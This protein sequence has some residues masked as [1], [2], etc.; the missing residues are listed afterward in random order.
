MPIQ[1]FNPH[2]P[3][4]D[5][6][7]AALK[8]IVPEA[9]EDGRLNI[10]TLREVLQPNLDPE[11][12]VD[13]DGERFGLIWPG[14]KEARRLA[15]IPS[16]GTL[17]PVYGEGLK[18]DGTPDTDGQNDS[19]NVFIEGENLEVLKIMQKAYAGRVKMIY[20]DPPYNT[21]NDFVYDDNFTEPL[22]HY[23]RRTGQVDDEGQNLTTNTK[24]DG[25][26]HS[27]WL[28]MMYPRLRLAKD[29][30]VEEGLLFVSIDDSEVTNLKLLLDE[31]F[32]AE[33]FYSQITVQSNKRGQTYKEIAKTHEYLLIYSKSDQ[34]E[35]L[36][37]EK[38]G[39]ALPYT[40]QKGSYD[41]WELRNRNPKFGRHNRPNLFYPFY[42]DPR[43]QAIDGAYTISL[44]RN[45]RYCQEILPRNSKGEDSCWRWGKDKAQN[46]L[47]KDVPDLVAKS[48][49]TGGY[50]IYQKSRKNTK[51]AKSI[52]LENNVISEKGTVELGELG[53]G[54]EFDHP[55]PMGLLEKILAI[56][57]EENDL[58]LDFFG[59]SGT[60][61][62]AIYFHNINKLHNIHYIIVQ[63]GLPS[64]SQSS[65]YSTLAEVT[66][67]RIK[68]TV[69]SD[70]ILQSADL[71][72]KAFMLSESQLIT[73][74]NNET[75]VLFEDISR[76]P[77][78]NLSSLL[79][80]IILSEGFPLNSSITLKTIED[81]K[82][83]SV[84]SNFHNFSLHCCFDETIAPAAAQEITL[85]ENDVL[86]CFDSALDDQTKLRLSDKGLVKTI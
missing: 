28:S 78:Y 54:K 18:A 37:L 17:A 12:T 7:L 13:D 40:D 11:G 71:G 79:W 61:A 20:I 60:T 85:G 72:F 57:V 70:Q 36:E 2:Y 83:H 10:D 19:R 8:Q 49:R 9:F 84:S 29:L 25:R 3:F 59:G 34:S 16:K 23:L 15:A 86:I 51:K 47:F 56:S 14:K 1:P 21:G 22:E 42:V 68:R 24:A 26:F 67:E 6:K 53:L 43:E 74:K 46:E 55:K 75:N 82:I 81:Q 45:E 35:I 63:I 62:S 32:G 44:K 41:L 27:R 66:R 77:Q 5:E 58:V 39:D 33:N 4:T 69:K 30:L 73:S 38:D 50:N 52:W 48:V 31:V 64:N 65:N 80:E 76:T